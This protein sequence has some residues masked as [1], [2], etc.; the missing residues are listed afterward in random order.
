MSI[1][2]MIECTDETK[3]TA[4]LLVSDLEEIFD[5]WATANKYQLAQVHG[6]QNVRSE[7]IEVEFQELKAGK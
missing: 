1:K 7:F 6:T 4:R 5:S 2:I 3:G